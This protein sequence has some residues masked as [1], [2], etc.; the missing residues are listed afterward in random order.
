MRIRCA[1]R[2]ADG[3]RAVRGLRGCCLVRTGCAGVV[4]SRAGLINRMTERRTDRIPGNARRGDLG[5]VPAL[6]TGVP[7]ACPAETDHGRDDIEQRGKPEQHRRRHDHWPAQRPVENEHRDPDREHAVHRDRRQPEED[8][9]P[10][11][12]LGQLVHDSQYSARDRRGRVSS[13]SGGAPRVSWKRRRPLRGHDA[14]RALSLGERLDQQDD[15]REDQ[16]HHAG[17][18]PEEAVGDG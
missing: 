15:R 18:Q 7:H 11:P 2:G 5:V 13:V 6:L 10:G 16:P 3:G 1:R 8:T 9:E 17:R 12:P 14:A 4:V